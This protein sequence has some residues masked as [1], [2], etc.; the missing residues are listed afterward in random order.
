MSVKKK[1][2]SSA[3]SRIIKRKQLI[4]CT[5]QVQPLVGPGVLGIG[6]G[7]AD[8]Q[9]TAARVCRV[10]TVSQTQREVSAHVTALSP[11]D[12]PPG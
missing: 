6:T 5:I 4:V 3:V 7:P 8:G 10:V 2:K 9:K 1:K 12:D 11:H